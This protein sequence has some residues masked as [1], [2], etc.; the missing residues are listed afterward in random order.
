M[1][2]QLR[3]E[4]STAMAELKR[5]SRPLSSLVERIGTVAAD[6]KQALEGDPARGAQLV[7]E[8]KFDPPDLKKLADL[9]DAV[10]TKTRDLKELEE[11]I[12]E[13]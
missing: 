11:Q 13:F 3:S 1:A 12:K 7:H 10:Y 9:I 2:K 6:P 8:L 4:I 5:C